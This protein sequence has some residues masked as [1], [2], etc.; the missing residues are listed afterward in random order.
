MKDLIFYELSLFYELGK[1][2]II[3]LENLTDFQKLWKPLWIC[4]RVQTRRPG[5]QTQISREHVQA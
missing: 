3:T 4:H 1:E 2:H 5:E